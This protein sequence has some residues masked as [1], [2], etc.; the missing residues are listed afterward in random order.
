M[1]RDGF[2]QDLK[3]RDVAEDEMEQSILLA[4]RFEDYLQ[5]PESSGLPTPEAVHAFSAVLIQEEVNTWDNYV[6]LARYGR[7]V[8]DN[9]IYVSVVELLDVL[10]Q[11]AGCRGGSDP[12]DTLQQ[13]GLGFQTRM[14]V[15]PFMNLALHLRDLGVDVGYQAL[16]R[17]T[18]I[19][20]GR[21]RLQA[22]VLL[23]TQSLQSHHM[24]HQSLQFTHFRRGGCPGFG[25]LHP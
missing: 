20:R 5:G 17:N 16:Q 4:E 15:D 14:L 21:L 13:G 3:E 6:T 19:A 10:T 7:F 11:Q 24:A 8:D 23:G 1:D 9:D 25:L 2:R 12:R 18:Y 22:I